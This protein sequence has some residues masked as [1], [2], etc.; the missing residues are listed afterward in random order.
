MNLLDSTTHHYDIINFQPHI[1]IVELNKKYDLLCMYWTTDCV[2]P[3]LDK[4][5]ST[6]AA[7]FR[8]MIL[9]GAHQD[10]MAENNKLR[11]SFLANSSHGNG[12]LHSLTNT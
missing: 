2:K 12:W 1:I 11:S 9:C 7:D 6:S 8:H 4:V 3:C 10:V 5:I